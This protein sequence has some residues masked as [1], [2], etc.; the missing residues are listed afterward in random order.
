ML[1]TQGFEAPADM[2]FFSSMQWIFE[3]SRCFVNDS[4]RLAT[5]Y[6]EDGDENKVVVLSS[7]DCA[8]RHFSFQMFLSTISFIPQFS[9][10][11]PKTGTSFCRHYFLALTLVCRARKLSLWQTIDALFDTATYETVAPSPH[12]VKWLRST[13]RTL[14]SFFFLLFANAMRSTMLDMLKIQNSP[15]CRWT[16]R[17]VAAKICQILSNHVPRRGHNVTTHIISP[18]AHAP[19]G[20]W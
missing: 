8:R 16:M 1:V 7:R 3:P 19:R 15:V 11:L 12:L 10:P 9:L 13:N 5:E 18:H 6:N 14:S 17:N 20:A 4:W 2:I